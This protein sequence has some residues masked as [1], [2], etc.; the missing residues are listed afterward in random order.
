MKVTGE[1]TLW[2]NCMILL[3]AYGVPTL[4]ENI[5]TID[6]GTACGKFSCG[7]WW[8]QISTVKRLRIIVGYLIKHWFSL[9][10]LH[11]KMAVST[12]T[13]IGPK[14][15]KLQVLLQVYLLQNMTG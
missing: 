14:A 15:T 1:S 5:V 2:F 11:F 9:H 6:V 8:L 12:G 10:T 3:P 13:I 7:L 4:G